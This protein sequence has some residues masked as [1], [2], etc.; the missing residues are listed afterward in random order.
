MTQ[1]ESGFIDANGLRLH[2]LTWRPESSDGP[3]VVL[4]HATGFMA[5]LWQPIAERLAEAG[6]TVYAYDARGHGDS[7]KPEVTAES[8]DWRRF[9]E[10][11][12]GFLDHFQLR[13]VS[14]VGH[15]MGAAS[16]LFLAG[17][18]PEYF[19]RTVAI[20]PIVIPGGFVPD[21]TRMA[22][23]SGGARKRRMVFRDTDELV[24]QYRTRPTF[25]RWPVEMLRLYA[26]HGTFRREDGQ[27]E[28]K[29]T[30][31][32][33]GEIFARSYTLPVWDALPSVEVPA[34]VMR[35]ENTEPFIHMVAEQVSQRLPGARL[36]TF[37]DS[38]H[39]LPMEQPNAVA[40]EV[41]AFLSSAPPSPSRSP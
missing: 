8:Y 19:S 27:I 32:V 25:Q 5:R 22:Q 21:E 26:E 29:C 4:N 31:A 18:A 33:E 9:S 13:D 20:E 2:T 11:L 23:M 38:G 10:D 40:D 6:Y 37:P 1:P 16:A 7:D 14:I 24:E 39:L 35:G 17:H 34:L 41:L 30:G 15:S 12:R 36:I 3:P 28:L